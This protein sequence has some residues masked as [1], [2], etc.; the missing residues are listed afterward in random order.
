MNKKLLDMLNEQ[1]CFEI[2]SSVNYANMS[3]LAAR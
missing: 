2:M 1:M 3:A